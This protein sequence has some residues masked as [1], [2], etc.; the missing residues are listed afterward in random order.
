[1]LYYVPKVMIYRTG[2]YTH[3]KGIGQDIEMMLKFVNNDDAQKAVI[4]FSTL[5][6]VEYDK[7][8]EVKEEEEEGKDSK[9]EKKDSKKEKAGMFVRP[10]KT[11]KVKKSML[12]N[13]DVDLPLDSVTIEKKDLLDRDTG[14][15][16]LA[17]ANAEEKRNKEDM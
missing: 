6:D 15:G 9:E 16:T 10:D 12:L 14:G 2:K 13:A 3:Y 1:M 7:F 17:T 11:D 5:D 8:E 4:S